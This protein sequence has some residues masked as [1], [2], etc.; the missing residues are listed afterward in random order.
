VTVPLSYAEELYALRA[1]IHMVAERLI[2][3]AAP[4]EP[5]AAGKPW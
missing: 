5:A 1:H 2:D 4:V 3:P